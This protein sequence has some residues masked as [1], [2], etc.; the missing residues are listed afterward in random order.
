M[1]FPVFDLHCDTAFALLGADYTKHISLLENDCH[2]DLKRA[3][4]HPAYTQC[5]ACFTC[6]PE[7]LDVPIE[8]E[9]LF[10]LEYENL[11]TELDKNKQIIRLA[12]SAADI[13]ENADAGLMSAILTLEGPAGFGFDSGKLPQLYEKGFRITTLSWN[14]G[15][16]L[17]GSHITG[18]GLTEKGRSY[19]KTAQQLGMVIDVSHISDQA[20]WDIMD[21]TEK[22]VIATHS[23]SRSVYGVSRNLTDDMFL[24]ICRCGGVAGINLYSEF[25]GDQADLDTVCDHIFHFIELDPSCKHIA[26]GGDLD[27]CDS[28]PEGFDGVQSYPSIAARLMDRGLSN[29]QIFNIF[30]N[31]ALGVIEQCCT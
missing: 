9:K 5:F 28:L 24:Q 14:E 12:K 22:P 17:T 23:N 31:N 7:S 1:S 4:A 15:N 20:F 27:G 11:M 16:C 25:L 26:I 3:S 19:V 29:H 13:R 8:P 21:M 10:L 30:W 2:I 6:L 18:G